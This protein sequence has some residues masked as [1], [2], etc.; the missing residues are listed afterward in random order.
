MHEFLVSHFGYYARNQ[1][2]INVKVLFGMFTKPNL[3]FR[4]PK[5][6]SGTITKNVSS[7]TVVLPHCYRPYHVNTL[8]K[9]SSSSFKFTFVRHPFTR[10]SSAYKWVTER[11]EG[12]ALNRFDTR[13]LEVIRKAG[14]INSFCRLLP[15]LLADKHLFLIHFY[16]Q[17]DFICAGGRLLVDHVGKYESFDEDCRLMHEQYGYELNISFGPNSKNKGKVQLENPVDSLLA[18]GV[19]ESSLDSLRSVY[20]RDFEI[21]EYSDSD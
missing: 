4:M 18:V 15:E 10:F 19:T 21:F 5:V 1:A 14:D 11:V 16:P 13:Q 3:Y 8:L 20:A 6:A 7:D 9:L 12:G 17:S 2:K